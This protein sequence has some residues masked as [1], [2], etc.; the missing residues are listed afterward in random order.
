MKG[1]FSADDADKRDPTLPPL[2][3]EGGFERS[4]K[5]GG[6]YCDHRS[7]DADPSPTL[8]ASRSVPPHK[9]EGGKKPKTARAR[10]MRKNMTPQEA[11]LWI[12]LRKLRARGYHFRRQAPFRGYFL[13]FVCFS[14]RLV[15]EVDGGGHG[16]GTQ[17]EHDR[18]RDA[19]LRRQGFHTLRVWNSDINS[20]LEGVVDT[21][22][23]ALASADK[24]DLR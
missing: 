4:E 16:E 17:A 5:T 19:V 7:V 2:Y 9:G 3:G 15:V 12:Y 18:V 20:N 8:I 10:E 22:L 23:H 24:N 21:N 1:R 11:H 14:R 6:E 13:D